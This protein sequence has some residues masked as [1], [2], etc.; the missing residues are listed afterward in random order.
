MS[1]R[2]GRVEFVAASYPGDAV[3]VFYEIQEGEVEVSGHTKDDFDS[4]LGE[5]GDEIIS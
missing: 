1:L 3:V 5:T 2:V 4:E